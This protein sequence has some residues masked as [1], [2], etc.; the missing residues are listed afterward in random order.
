MKSGSSDSHHSG[1]HSS[2]APRTRVCQH[3]STSGFHGT[4]SHTKTKSHPWR[5]I[6]VTGSE[7]WLRLLET[8]ART[9]K[10]KAFQNQAFLLMT[11]AWSPLTQPK[12]LGNI[13]QMCLAPLP[14]RI[15]KHSGGARNLR[16]LFVCQLRRRTRT[17]HG[18]H[19]ALQPTQHYWRGTGGP[20]GRSISP[21]GRDSGLTLLRT[22]NFGHDPENIGVLQRSILVF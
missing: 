21:D 9:R 17:E 4:C 22:L 1:S 19:G 6:G 10:S 3:R 13:C 7:S 14:A 5:K 11:L 8:L 16:S 20:A 12:V 2:E 15:G 18:E